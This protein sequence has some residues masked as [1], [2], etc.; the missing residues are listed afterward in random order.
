MFHLKTCDLRRWEL[1]DVGSVAKHANNRNVWLNLRD[2][3]PH[4]YT[5]ADAEQWVSLTSREDPLVHLAIAVDGHAVGGISIE[6]QPDVFKRSAEI[7]YWLS[8]DFWGRGIMTEAVQAFTL[9]AI[10]HFGLC[11]VFA[12]VFDSN[13]ASA[14]VLEKVG[15]QFEG[16]MRRSVVKAGVVRDQLLYA[17]VVDTGFGP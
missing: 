4:P 9:Y 6:L 2:R 13:P 3:F 11:R 5:P 17:Y 7:G 14:R 16:R 12:G 10:E 15:Y 8:E 1:S